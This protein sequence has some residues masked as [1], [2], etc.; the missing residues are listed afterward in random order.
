MLGGD[1]RADLKQRADEQVLRGGRGGRR[2]PA[3]DTLPDQV[4]ATHRMVPRGHHQPRREREME[5]GGAR[6]GAG[7]D[8]ELAREIVDDAGD[9]VLD[10]QRAL[11]PIRRQQQLP[12]GRGDRQSAKQPPAALIGERDVQPAENP[13]RRQE[14]GARRT[15]HRDATGGDVDAPDHPFPQVG[16][17]RGRVAGGAQKRC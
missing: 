15:E 17:W 3:F 11:M 10:H 6:G 2:E 13:R 8:G 9:H 5:R 16:R 7:H 1:A 4:R 14:I 12:R